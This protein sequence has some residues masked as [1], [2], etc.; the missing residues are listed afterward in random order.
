MDINTNVSQQATASLTPLKVGSGK[1]SV[2]APVKLLTDSVN[3]VEVKLPDA[4]VAT[5]AKVKGPK[6]DV[7]LKKAVDDLNGYIQNVQRNLQF[8]IDEDSGTMVV[9]VIDSKTEKVIR[10]IPNEETLRLARS[11]SEDKHDATLNIF[12]S[13]A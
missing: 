11:L 10:Q 4:G 9:K 1:P 8:S 12:S 3:K 7:N 13:R 6:D 5:D 2:E